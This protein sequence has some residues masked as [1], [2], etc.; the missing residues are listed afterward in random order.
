MTEPHARE[1]AV[2]REAAAAASELLLRYFD[3]GVE[4]EAKGDRDLVSVADRD[5]EAVVR[6]V[7]AASF[8]DDLVVGEEGAAV[9]A[10]D[11][12]GRRRW[13]VDPLDGTT[14]FVKGRRMWGVSIGFCGPDDRVHVGVV[15][16]PRQGETYTAVRG[17]GAARDGRP[18]RVST[19]SAV[20]DALFTTGSHGDPRAFLPA[21]G[22]VMEQALSLRVTGALAPDLCELAAGESDGLWALEPGPWDV[23]AGTLIAAEAGAVVTDLAGTPLRAP[24]V[25]GVVAAPPT[26]HADLLRLLRDD[27]A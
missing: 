2:A 19:T 21:W 11:A 12:A 27:T 7:I 3:K 22:R 26:L 24:H 8:P 10:A 4:V 5:A 1:L 20:R 23:A 17:H 13:Y 14:N 9:S 18:L 6:R 15:T 16:V 25:D